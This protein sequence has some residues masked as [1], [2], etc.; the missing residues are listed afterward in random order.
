MRGVLSIMK[1]GFP[2]G[3]ML[4]AILR[5]VGVHPRILSLGVSIRGP[6]HKRT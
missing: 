4:F 5:R 1:D 3:F 6:G 2:S